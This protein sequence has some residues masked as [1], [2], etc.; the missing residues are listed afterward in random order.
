MK[1]LGITD[2]FTVGG[3]I[4]KKLLYIVLLTSF[5]IS[6]LPAKGQ[7]SYL[8]GSDIVSFANDYQNIPYKFGGTTIEGFDCSGFLLFVFN[9]F[10]LSLPRTSEE[11]FKVGVPIEQ[12]E[13]KLGDLV[14]F[15]NTYK[16]DI[17][18]SG[19]YVGNNEFIS[20]TS[21]GVL[22][23]RLDNVYWSSKYTGAKRVLQDGKF[24][25]ET[26][27][28]NFDEVITEDEDDVYSKDPIELLAFSDLSNDHFAFEA[29]QQLSSKGIISGYTDD[30]FRPT[31]FVT[32]GQAA[33]II[34]RILQQQPRTI[35]Y[36]SDVSIHN[37]FVKDIAAIKELGVIN[38]F[39]D[40]TFR[41]NDTMTRAQMAV[42]VK[43]AFNINTLSSVSLATQTVYKDV[44]SSYWAYEAIVTMNLIDRTQ[45]F[46][47]SFYRSG[48]AATRADFS[49][50]VYNGL[51]SR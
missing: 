11:Q 20:A 23:A 1:L 7:A 3:R 6:F 38:G 45:G 35:Q 44:P 12:E 41:P 32:R 14:F 34:N 10:G 36:F 42:I 22:I 47:T 29:I 5:L 26:T 2:V 19:I 21:N 33:A 30:T 37:G 31:D 8:T 48:D 18:H 13:L 27:D 43:N 39:S 17:S 15:S 40:G 4:M 50:A 24:L 49:A 9:H 25:L 51:N 16:A 46:K 28:K